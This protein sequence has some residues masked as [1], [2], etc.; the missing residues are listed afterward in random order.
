MLMKVEATRPSTYH[1]GWKLNQSKFH[2]TMR[3]LGLTHWNLLSSLRGPIL[4]LS[5]I[6]NHQF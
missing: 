3:Q 1:K 4:N 6:F 2:D 5:I